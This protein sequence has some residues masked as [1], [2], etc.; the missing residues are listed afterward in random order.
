MNSPASRPSPLP[1]VEELLLHRGDMLLVHRLHAA[2]AEEV[3]VECEVRGEAW[4]AEADGAMP[5]WVGIE[6]MAQ[7]VGVYSGWVARQRG[8]APR[9]GYLLGTRSYT[10][11]VP[12]FPVGAVLGVRARSVFRD[13]SGLGAFDCTLQMAGETLAQATLK[14]FETNEGER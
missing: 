1:P 5:A 6:L 8:E 3:E 14:V 12:R 10:C 4:Y 7:A 2:S 13:E 11:K 9:L